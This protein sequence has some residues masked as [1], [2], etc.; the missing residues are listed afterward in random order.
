MSVFSGNR[1][2]S[3][4]AMLALAVLVGGCDDEV[5]QPVVLPTPSGGALLQSYVAIGNSITAGFQSGGINDSTQL[6]S[7]A[8]LLAQA[9]GHTVGETFNVPLMNK[10]GCPAPIVNIFTQERLS[11]IPCALRQAPLPHVLHNVAVPGAA[12][13]DA[14]NNL[15]PTSS[16][17]ALTSFFLGGRTQL[18]AAAAANPTFVTVFI[19]NNDALGAVLEVGNAGDPSL[20]KDPATF[21]TEYA[22][23]MDGLDAIPSIQGGVL[24]GTVQVASAPYLTQ[25]RV[26]KG[27]EAQFDA[28][29]QNGL[30]SAF[31]TVPGVPPGTTLTAIGVSANF[32][33][34]NLN[35]LAS[36]PLTATDT[37][38]A[39]VPFH[40]GG[41]LL[42]TASARAVDSATVDSLFT[43][44][45]QVLMALGGAPIVPDSALIPAPTTV[46]CSVAD[47]VTAAEVANIFAAVTQYNVAIKA[48]ADERDWVFLDPNALLL[49]L[50]ADPTAIRPFPAFPGT[51]APS[52]TLNTPFGTAISLD[53]FHPSASTHK[54]VANA[55]VAAINA[56]YGTSISA[57]P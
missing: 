53:G 2:W 8:V 26:W 47:A 43:F 25:G 32:L 16:G 22:M 31:Q 11:T 56:A 20:V 40:M 23:M 41:P 3:G 36:V 37:A 5:V 57:I 12:A 14:T 29:A 52:E 7:Y 46:D 13:I 17:N 34:V 10:P 1:R 54:A 4:A 6:Q 15:A 21:A 44:A 45:G 42:S 49:Q 51:A 9:M 27:F 38:W 33:D 39:S 19:G 50:L 55:L 18:E 30:D 48:E 35:C 24:F 28:L